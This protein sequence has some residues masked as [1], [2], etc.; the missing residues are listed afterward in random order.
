MFKQLK[1]KMMTYG[2]HL[3]EMKQAI[4][5]PTVPAWFQRDLN[6]LKKQIG[7][8]TRFPFGKMWPI[9]N[10]RKSQAGLMKGHYF[11]QDLYVAKLI[12]RANPIKHLDI[13]SRVDGFVAHVASYRE[14]EIIDIRPINSRV[15]HIQFRQADLMELPEDLKNYCD[16]VS[17]LHVIEHFGLGRY[18]DP[19]DYL[20]HEKAIKNIAQILKP[21]GIFY[22][23]VPIGPQRI[24]F[25]AHR[26]F[27]LAYL[28]TLLQEE[29]AIQSF[30]YVD[31]KGDFFEEIPLSNDVVETNAGCTF[32]CGIYTLKK[33]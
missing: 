1:K 18:N 17:S 21:G 25:N 30:S 16:S 31:D 26:V 14:I 32:G 7:F 13:G 9:Y 2:I 10:E 27:S 22:F 15:E 4:K 6:T 29:F 23:S 33:K 19:I 28:N 20:G 12:F 5:G 3:D 11:H 8:D 24:E